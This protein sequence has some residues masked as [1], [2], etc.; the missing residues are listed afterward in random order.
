MKKDIHPKD[1]RQV[2]FLD[3]SSKAQFLIYSTA[4]TKETGKWEDGK[5]YPLV[6]VE[7]SSASHPA[8]TGQD[9]VVDTAGR[10]QKFKLRQAKATPQRALGKSIKKAAK[11]KRRASAKL[12]SGKQSR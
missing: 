12:P 5:E 9:L 1:Y 2:I 11:A 10:V 4:H 3:N 7:V 6:R 8:Y